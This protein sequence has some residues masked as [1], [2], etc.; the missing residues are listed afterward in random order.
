MKKKQAQNRRRRKEVRKKEKKG[1]RR[2]RSRKRVFYSHKTNSQSDYFSLLCV[3]RPNMF[4]SVTAFMNF[5]TF[6]CRL[7]LTG[8]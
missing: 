7:E 3:L 1:R 2:S 5:F 6:F 4:A 8:G